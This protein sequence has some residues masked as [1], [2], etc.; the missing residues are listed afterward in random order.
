MNDVSNWKPIAPI[1]MCYCESDEQVLYNNAIV[2][3]DNM[4]ALGANNVRAKSAGKKFGHNQCAGFSVIYTKY[5]FDSFLKGSKKG[6]KGPLV[7]RTLLG[8][9]KLF[10]KKK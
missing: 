2:T 9:Y 5:Y 8:I 6:R 7:K 1:Q 10:I 3:R 4:L